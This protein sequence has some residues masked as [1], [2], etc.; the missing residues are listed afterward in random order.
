MKKKSSLVDATNFIICD[1]SGMSWWMPTTKIKAGD[2]VKKDDK[3]YYI[4]STENGRVKVINYSESKEDNLVSELN[5]FLNKE[6][7]KKLVTPFSKGLEMDDQAMKFMMMSSMMNGDTNNNGINPM[8]LM[9]MSN[10]NESDA[11]DNSLM[12]FMMMS[13]MMNGDNTN[14]N[15]INPMMLMMMSKKGGL[16]DLFKI[17]ND[18][19]KENEE[20]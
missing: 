8:M 19:G 6:I 15:G 14:N 18:S 12:K 1:L 7:F 4:I 2:I 11:S 10:A 9:M 16:E 20:K 13:S 3:Y 17:N 5:L